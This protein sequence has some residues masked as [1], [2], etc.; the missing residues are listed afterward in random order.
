MR[1]WVLAAIVGVGAT[2]AWAE[3]QDDAPPPRVST[4][5]S[6]V[7]N[8]ESRLVSLRPERPAAYLEL[9]ELVLQEASTAEDRRLARELLV[10]ALS[11][12]TARREDPNAAGVASSAC[13]ALAS[14]ADD[15][16]TARWLGA[17]GASLAPDASLDVS[18][19]DAAAGAARDPAALDVANALGLARI[20]EGKRAER[21]L[22]RPGAGELLERMDKVLQPG[23]GGGAQRVR[24]MIESYPWCPQCRNRRT[25]KDASGVQVCPTCK[26]LPGPNLPD[27]ELINHL[28]A[29]SVLLSGVQR[30]WAAQILADEGAPLRDLD[31]AE[32]AATLRVD[33]SKTVWKNGAWA[34]PAP[35]R[36]KAEG[37]ARAAD[38]A[39]GS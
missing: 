1:A 21:L 20:G 19:Q 33:P 9:G 31:P 23:V 4:L 15:Q 29:E 17:V 18:T 3:R 22:A 14:A 10:L 7:E 30:S 27:E 25:F 11:T 5:A 28:R 13:L 34:A 12:A 2:P 8:L 24:R 37:A 6:R 38:P 32:V 36:P 16:P 35:A 26:G 39:K